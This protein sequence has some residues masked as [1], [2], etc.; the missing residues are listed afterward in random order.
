MWWQCILIVHANNR[1]SAINQQ[2]AIKTIRKF[3]FSVSAVWNGREA[4][5]Y[6]LLP[7]S[8]SSPKPDIILMDVQMPILDGY[9]ATHLIRH[10]SPYSSIAS[11]RNLPIVAMTASAIQGDKEKCRK[12]GMDD[13]LAKPVK[14]KTLENMLLKWAVEGKRTSRIHQPVDSPDGNDHDPHC[15]DDH[16][17]PLSTTPSSTND[18]QIPITTVK[19][20]TGI[21]RIGSREPRFTGSSDSTSSSGQQKRDD[22]AKANLPGPGNEGDRGLQRVEAEEKATSLRDD[23]LLAA[24][25]SSPFTARHQQQPPSKHTS[26]TLPRAMLTEENITRLGQQNDRASIFADASINHNDMHGDAPNHSDEERSSLVVG[27]SGLHSR[28]SSTELDTVGSLHSLTVDGETPG[29]SGGRRSMRGWL[30]R[31][32]SDRSLVTVRQ[33]DIGGYAGRAGLSEGTRTVSGG[34]GGIVKA[35][36]GADGAVD[37]ERLGDESEES[38]DE[39]GGE[40]EVC[41]RPRDE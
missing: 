25:E 22:A 9:R 34:S 37:E 19:P 14:G 18:G 12:A 4:L 24:S 15:K 3:G 1:R 20:A 11:I 27:A 13:Y 8:A 32:E 26:E 31:H 28:Q 21:S 36:R 33:G 10:H 29:A 40:E 38:G 39:E 35:G 5:D 6:L 16:L 23:K 41:D 2:I 7:S 17:P 30:A